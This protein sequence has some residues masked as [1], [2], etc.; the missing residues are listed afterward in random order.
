M[1][2]VTESGAIFSAVILHR[3]LAFAPA[4]RIIDLTFQTEASP[5]NPVLR[6][7]AHM[8]NELPCPNPTCTHVV[9]AAQVQGATALK[10]PRCGQVF[11]LRSSGPSAGSTPGALPKT[12]PGGQPTMTPSAVPNKPLHGDEL[13]ISQ[14]PTTLQRKRAVPTS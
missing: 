6:D 13:E 9:G 8:P 5:S 11:Q 3:H 10:C 14:A 1:H 2:D 12:P 4:K 7:R